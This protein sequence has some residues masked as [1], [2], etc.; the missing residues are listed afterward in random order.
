MKV[1]DDVWFIDLSV[2]SRPMFGQVVSDVRHG[3]VEV[4]RD[5]DRYLC[6][7]DRVYKTKRAAWDWIVAH[8]EAELAIA[9]ARRDGDIQ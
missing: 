8:I 3:L 9:K 6:R 7:V 1:G 2:E 4:R 5:T